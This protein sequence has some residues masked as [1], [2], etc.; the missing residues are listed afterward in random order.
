M[1]QQR[2]RSSYER[3]SSRQKQQSNKQQAASFAAG[4]C[5][6]MYKKQQHGS[7]VQQLSCCT[8]ALCSAGEREEGSNDP[9]SP[10][11]ARFLARHLCWFPGPAP[12]PHPLV[13]PVT[14]GGQRMSTC[15]SCAKQI[16]MFDQKVTLGRYTYH[17]S[18]AKCAICLRAL[19]SSNFVLTDE[20]GVSSESM[21]SWIDCLDSRRKL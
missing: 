10:L 5:S 17:R 18:C 11:L 1:Q 16:L 7:R 21:R 9:R 13:L 19:T 20:I 6:S 12:G 4:C 3:A 2:R 14:P 15:P 8:C